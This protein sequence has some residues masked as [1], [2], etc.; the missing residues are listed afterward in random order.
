M[1]DYQL[2]R[3]RV[4]QGADKAAE[5]IISNRKQ[6]VIL[7]NKA[8][9]SQRSRTTETTEYTQ[10]GIIMNYNIRST[11]SNRMEL[12]TP[13]G[14]KLFVSY[15]TVVGFYSPLL[16]DKDEDDFSSN[17]PDALP[18]SLWG[19]R[20]RE[21]EWGTSTAKHLSGWGSI[22][23]ERLGKIKFGQAYD[24]AYGDMIRK[25]SPDE[26]ARN[27]QAQAPV[28]EAMEALEE[29]DDDSRRRD[30]TRCI[31]RAKETLTKAIRHFEVS[32]SV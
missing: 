11:G 29:I 20:F 25:L 26:R 27:L 28:Y 24:R 6:R 8:G 15:E 2:Y 7:C 32:R 4:L 12:T 21:N 19:F 18:Q 23:G 14:I 17:K 16:R 31:E 22:R 9:D 10:G 30:I 3:G 5:S 1:S 13:G